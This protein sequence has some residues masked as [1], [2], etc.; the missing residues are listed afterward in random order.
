MFRSDHHS[1]HGST[2]PINTA[3][4]EVQTRWGQLRHTGE[5]W[6]DRAANPPKRVADS[7]AKRNGVEHMDLLVEEVE[8]S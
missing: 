7:G 6:P 3:Q 8:K 2:G 4:V 5:S 1:P